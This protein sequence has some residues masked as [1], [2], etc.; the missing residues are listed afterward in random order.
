M[1]DW[2]GKGCLVCR[3]L[4]ESGRQPPELAVRYDLHSRLHKCSSC[5]TLWEQHERYADTI[6]EA[7]AKQLYPQA[8]GSGT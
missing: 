6:D 3:G 8:F 1:T 2:N 4:W 7:E 5:E